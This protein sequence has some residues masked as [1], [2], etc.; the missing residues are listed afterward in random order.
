MFKSYRHSFKECNSK[1]I[2]MCKF[3][4]MISAIV[5]LAIVVSSLFG[6]S[7]SVNAASSKTLYLNADLLTK[8]GTQPAYT[9]TCACYALAYCRTMLDNS[10]HY[11][12]EYNRYGADQYNAS[13]VWG[14]G[15]Y[16]TKAASNRAGV[17]KA[18][19]DSINNDRPIIIHLNHS[20][21]GQHWVAVVG[22]QNVSDVNSMTESNLLVIDSIHGFKGTPETLS[23]YTLNTSY[24]YAVANSGSVSG[25][26]PS[27][28]YASIENGEYYL[29]NVAT[30]K[31]LAVDGGKDAQAQNI[32]VADFTGGNEMKISVTK[33]SNG[34]V[35]KPLC[36]SS[37]VVNVYADNVVSGKN[38][39]LYDNTNHSS[40]RWQFESVDGGYVI[41]NS[42][43]SSCVLDVSGTNVMVSSNTGANSQKWVLE[44]VNKVVYPGKPVLN[45]R[46][47]TSSEYTQFWWDA[48]SN[49]DE[50]EIKIY[51]SNTG[52][53]A[54]YYTGVKGTNYQAKLEPGTYTAHAM[55]IDNDLRDTDCWWT[56][57]DSISFTVEEGEEIAPV[58]M[59]EYNGHT[60]ELYDAVMPW[61]KAKLYCEE[62][63]GHLVTT[64]SKTE[65][66]AVQELV[67][68][69]QY[70][71]YWI[72]YSDIEN[73]GNFV[74]VNG[75]NVTYINWAEGEPNNYE[76]DEDC[77]VLKNDA[78]CERNDVCNMYARYTV[79]FICELEY[80]HTH[81]YAIT[82][83]VPSTCQT[84]GYTVYTCDCGDIFTE[85]YS[86]LGEHEAADEWTVIKLPTETENGVACRLC[87]HCNTQVDYMVIYKEEIDDNGNYVPRGFENVKAEIADP[88]NG[89]IRF[90]WSGIDIADHYTFDIYSNDL[91]R[92]VSIDTKDL[93]YLWSSVAVTEGMFCVTAKNA[94]G[95]IL[96]E[97]GFLTFCYNVVNSDWWG[98]YGDVDLNSKINIK[99]ATAIQKA[100][101]K[102]TE[103]SKA[104]LVAADVNSDGKV[105]VKDATAIQKYL[106]NI[107]V[108]SCIGEEFACGESIYTLE[109]I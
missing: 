16:S 66:E 33:E 94:E 103:L 9:Y 30:G 5:V 4:R 54:Y 89:D 1:G 108:D 38:V 93:S 22:Y 85:N 28:N 72:G 18:C 99:D 77:A 25:T 41:H 24:R 58:A 68:K 96:V 86:E 42:Q 35:M 47:N 82:E 59:I 13:C 97:S 27:V 74:A 10:V 73:E 92:V 8:V 43:N 49:T 12:S 52:D 67:S 81:H 61:D 45:V 63:G 88:E 6:F 2:I 76:G 109:V 71:V 46:A 36:T 75:E 37:R 104:S 102:I 64:S 34:Y 80:S 21:Y 40:Q 91:K 98:K 44:P 11:Y 83:E 62:I 101:A 87:K 84:R 23:G 90:T 31:Y 48:T 17:F 95:E 15:D 57:G 3:K 105:N 56:H 107:P 65:L 106:A 26:T 50:Y 100:T 70:S 79:G 7:V 20:K 39:C 78:L 19:Y 69:G 53:M 51:D 29:K 32:S 14:W 60:Y 55:S